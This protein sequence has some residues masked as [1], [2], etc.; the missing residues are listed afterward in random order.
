MRKSLIG[1]V[2][3][4]AM[5]DTVVVEVSWRKP[6]PLYKKLLSRSQK[7]KVALGENKVVIGDSVKIVETRPVAKGKFF[8]IAEIKTKQSEKKGETA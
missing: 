7:F 3:S 6:H 4:V 2:V 8:A 5:K 1:K